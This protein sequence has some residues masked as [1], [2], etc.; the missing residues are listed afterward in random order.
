MLESFPDCMIL[1]DGI[2]WI[3]LHH[4]F[5]HVVELSW[6]LPILSQCVDPHV[7]FLSAAFV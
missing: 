3:A 1:L 4:F 7:S 6:I 2:L 5:E